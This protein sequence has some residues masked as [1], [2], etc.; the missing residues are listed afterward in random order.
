MGVLLLFDAGLM[1]IGNVL[2]LG[3]ITA[4]IGPRSTFTF[5]SRK[6]KIKGTICFL[7]GIFLVLSKYPFIGFAVEIFGFLN[8]FGD[9]FPVVFGFLK[10]LPIIGPILSHPALSRVVPRESRTRV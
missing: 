10:R 8:L 2:F 5:F 3:G 9:F 1:A 6:E 4:I 7:G